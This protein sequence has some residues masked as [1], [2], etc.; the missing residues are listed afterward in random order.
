[1]SEGSPRSLLAIISITALAVGGLAWFLM[2]GGES[3]P[4]TEG[5]PEAV[6]ATR[7]EIRGE[8]KAPAV[9]SRGR[10]SS[11]GASRGTSGF[12]DASEEVRT[13]VQTTF[14]DFPPPHQPNAI[15]TRLAGMDRWFEEQWPNHPYEW[16]APDCEEAPCV[17][18]LSIDMASFNNDEERGGE[19]WI[20]T[21]AE[22]EERLGW[23]TYGEY[24]DDGSDGMWHF[25]F[26]GLP[27]EL[28]AD[29]RAAIIY[30]DS[31]T[32]RRRDLLGDRLNVDR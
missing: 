13:G 26:F 2:A 27:E 19:V 7:G 16:H 6:P 8:G 14:E 3:A 23:E 4:E 20:A 28:A 25:G 1:M 12:G 30:S 18:G 5:A 10:G 17:F 9:H 21:K 31:A 15:K 22:V 11:I 32:E 24:V 29:F